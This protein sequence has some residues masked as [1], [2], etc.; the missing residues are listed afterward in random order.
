MSELQTIQSWLS[1]ELELYGIDA[2]IYT[3]HV[4]NLLVNS[5]YMTDLH[6]AQKE[7]NIFAS[8]PGSK[9]RK[10]KH[11]YNKRSNSFHEQMRYREGKPPK[12]NSR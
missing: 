5:R 9:K 11:K 2:V 10:P 8:L 3:R 7:E 1:S 4:I 12:A 6:L